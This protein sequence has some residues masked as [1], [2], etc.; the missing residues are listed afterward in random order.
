MGYWRDC[1]YSNW[2]WLDE[3]LH[4]HFINWHMDRIP[5]YFWLRPR[6]WFTNGT[7]FVPF[8][9]SETY[10]NMFQACTRHAEQ[11]EAR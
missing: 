9:D 7:L 1:T 3:H 4:S 10:T 5:N 11:R 2:L 8:S 6:V